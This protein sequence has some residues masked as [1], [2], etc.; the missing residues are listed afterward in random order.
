MPSLSP[1]YKRP[2]PLPSSPYRQHPLVCLT[3]LV[4]SL[5]HLRCTHT[6][7]TP[8]SLRHPPSLLLLAMP[9]SQ[10]DFTFVDYKRNRPYYDQPVDVL[11]SD[12]KTD[13]KRLRQFSVHFQG[14]IAAVISNFVPIPSVR[15]VTDLLMQAKGVITG[16][17]ALA[18]LYPGILRG[19]DDDSHAPSSP[20][21]D[22]THYDKDGFEF[23]VR[24]FYKTY[25]SDGPRD[26]PPRFKSLPIL[27]PRDHHADLVQ[28]FL[29]LGY[30]SR[31]VPH[32]FCAMTYPDSHLFGL[33]FYTIN[34]LCHPSGDR[35]VYVLSS[36]N[37]NAFYPLASS[38][39]SADLLT[40]S[41]SFMYCAY[42]GLTLTGK[43]L[44]LDRFS[45]HG[46]EL[47]AM[48]MDV[49]NSFRQWEPHVC[50]DYSHCPHRLRNQTD[51]IGFYHSLSR[52]PHAEQIYED[53]TR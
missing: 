32:A 6:S 1:S 19:L 34:I 8:S 40:I 43:A 14:R 37:L 12:A 21:S 3:Y 38:S 42:P 29:D 35:F 48:G 46:S 9:H 25:V 20:Q 47:C 23:Y 16:F 11:L 53:V 31:D 22:D 36:P 24:G 27:V 13:P 2:P 52:E 26:K 51:G 44:C 45:H 4:L 15:S 49:Q 30:V 28:F 50:P 18:T 39:C 17:P 33:G 10:R 7:S 41:P 5:T